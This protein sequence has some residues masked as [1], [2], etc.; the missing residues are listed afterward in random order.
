MILDINSELYSVKQDE[1]L[2]FVLARYVVYG[3]EMMNP[4]ITD[5]I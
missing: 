4:L 5:P 3:I 2:T 1:E